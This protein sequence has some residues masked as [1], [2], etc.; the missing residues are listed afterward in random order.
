MLS[1]NFPIRLLLTAALLPFTLCILACD[2]HAQSTP[3]GW[4]T[5]TNVTG[6]CQ[7]AIPPDWTA[8]TAGPPG[9]V[10]TGTSYSVRF[11][12]TA[13]RA[14]FAQVQSITKRTWRIRPAFAV[15]S[16]SATRAIYRYS[17]ADWYEWTVIVA[18]TPACAATLTSPVANDSLAMQIAATLSPR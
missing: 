9:A 16:E 3:K 14:T 10:K 12:L 6:K 11:M 7:L 13:P 5:L 18:G 17:P 15:V 2:V 8:Q 1:V 4:R